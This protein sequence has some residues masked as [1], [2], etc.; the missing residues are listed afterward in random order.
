MHNLFVLYVAPKMKRNTKIEQSRK[1]P[2]KTLVIVLWRLGWRVHE[3]AFVTARDTPNYC[4]SSYLRPLFCVI[5]VVR[6]Y[7]YAMSF[8][9]RSNFFVSV[10][11]TY[12]Y[13]TMLLPLAIVDLTSP[14]TSPR[15]SRPVWRFS[16][17]S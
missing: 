1:E 2:K 13:I 8:R 4:C 7:Y 12:S 3:N 10:V 17:K 6:V 16:C 5:N 11:R 14:G 15:K 9:S